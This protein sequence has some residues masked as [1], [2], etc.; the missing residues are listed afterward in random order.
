MANMM[1]MM[2]Q[3]QAM[4]AKMTQMQ[5]ELSTR[6]VEFT[7]GGGMVTARAT[8]D[9]TLKGIEIDPKV[10]DP[11]DVDMLQDLVFTAVAGALN[12]GRE[13]MSE[14]MGKITKGLNIPGMSL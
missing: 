12:L 8:C 10:V 14:E 7:S 9:G 5:D 2:K 6:E 13:T 11:E 4:Q 1:K 3:A